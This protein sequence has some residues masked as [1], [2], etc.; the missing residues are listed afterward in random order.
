MLFVQMGD[1]PGDRADEGRGGVRL[2]RP[3]RQTIGQC[4]AG[5]QLRGEIE[6]TAALAGLVDLE[7]LRMMMTA[8]LFGISASG[9]EIAHAGVSLVG[10]ETQGDLAAVE[11]LASVVDEAETIAAEFTEDLIAGQRGR[12]GLSG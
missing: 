5:G 7:Q 12:T 9:G 4:R 11:Q 6:L 3:F 10:D 2:E 1:G 8:D